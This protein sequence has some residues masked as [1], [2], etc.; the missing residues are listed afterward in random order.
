MQ[1][2]NYGTLEVWA[3]ARQSVTRQG[4]VSRERRVPLRKRQP[5]RSDQLRAN[6][7]RYRTVFELAPDII[8]GLSVPDGAFTDLSPS[9]AI[10]VGWPVSDWIGKPFGSIVH[11]ADIPLAEE[12]FGMIGRGEVPPR[13]ELRIHTKAGGYVI[14]EIRAV[15][16]LEGGRVVGGFGIAR[17]ITQRKRMEEVQS[18][19]VEAGKVLALSHEPRETL[20]WITRLAVP[21]LGD[22][23]QSFVVEE[24]QAK[25][26]TG[27]HVDPRQ[28][29]YLAALLRRYPLTL[30]VPSPLTRVLRSGQQGIRDWNQ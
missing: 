25:W 23:A 13:H 27:V 7:E 6:E 9:F 29:V 11:A 26:R 10:I 20:D 2:V 1:S 21:I 8:F 5:E 12:I 18:L 14:V 3:D 24:G 4:G 15:P 22:W 16:R 28:G 30:D 17:D 19:L